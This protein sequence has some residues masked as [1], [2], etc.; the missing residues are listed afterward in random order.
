[1]SIDSMLKEY[2]ENQSKIDILIQR[3]NQIKDTVAEQ[4]INDKVDG[5]AS[6]SYDVDGFSFKVTKTNRM[7]VTI[8][9]DKMNEFKSNGGPVPDGL[10]V[11]KEEVHKATLKKMIDD[12]DTRLLEIDKLVKV[13]HTTNTQIKF[14]QS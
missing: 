9:K 7:N 11:A 12:Q 5:V 1:M 8:V 3:Q 4:I 6:K 10:I 14:E 2:Q 13:N